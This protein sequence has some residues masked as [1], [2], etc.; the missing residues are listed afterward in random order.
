MNYNEI[1]FFSSYHL[2]NRRVFF[3]AERGGDFNIGTV[4]IASSLVENIFL[5]LICIV[6]MLLNLCGTQSTDYSVQRSCFYLHGG[7]I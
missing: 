1:V 7:E 5:D 3:N 4:P 2:F 6:F